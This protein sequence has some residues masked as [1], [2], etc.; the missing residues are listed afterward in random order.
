M[1]AHSVVSLKPGNTPH[2]VVWSVTGGW[3]CWETV[4]LVRPPH[5]TTSLP[6]LQCVYTGVSFRPCIHSHTTHYNTKHS[7][8]ECYR[9]LMV[10]VTLLLVWPPHDHSNHLSTWL[11]VQHCIAYTSL[12]TLA[13]VGRTRDHRRLVWGRWHSVKVRDEI[14]CYL[15]TTVSTILLNVDVPNLTS[16]K[17]Y[18]TFWTYSDSTF[19]LTHSNPH[20]NSLLPH[21]HILTLTIILALKFVIFYFK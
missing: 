18:A 20:I 9:W 14:Q 1:C 2:T 15:T 13:A 8:V 12:G 17:V 21:T 19:K 10:L 4:L 7:G 3:W 16:Q 11:L 5:H 6:G